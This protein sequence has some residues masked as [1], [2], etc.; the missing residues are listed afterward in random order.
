[1]KI[2]DINFKHL[3]FLLLFL[4]SLHV[5]ID[6]ETLKIEN[7]SIGIQVNWSLKQVLIVMKRI[8]NLLNIVE[9]HA[10]KTTLNLL[11]ILFELVG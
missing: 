6:F 9:H 4:L 11:I 10:N 1:M 8:L 7:L 5:H 2:S 3:F